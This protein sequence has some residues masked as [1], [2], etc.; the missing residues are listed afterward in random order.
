MPRLRMTLEYDGTDFAGFQL[1][2]DARTVQGVVEAAI[3]EITREQRRL[4]PAGRTDAGV[5]ARGQV[6]HF[7][8]DTRLSPPDLQ[9]SLNAVLPRDVAVLQ[10]AD[11]RPDFD[12]RRDAR[13]K[14]YVYRILNRPEPSPLRARTHLHLRAPL[15]LAAMAE[16]AKSL[17][18]SHDFSA[19]RGAPGGVPEDESPRRSL[20]RLELVGRGDEI[21]IEAEGRSFLRH[22]VR[23]IAGTLVEVGQGRRPPSEVAEVLASRDRARA[24]PTA[25]AHGLCLE[26][27]SYD[28]EPGS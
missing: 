21:S 3:A 7:D 24:G 8:S 9:R 28:P 19:F 2:P 25:A 23:N 12:A 22:M 16:A 10:L 6:A 18:G 1:Q 13:A 27:V 15:D 20:D 11:A 4:I 14:L 5:H 26:R 17:L